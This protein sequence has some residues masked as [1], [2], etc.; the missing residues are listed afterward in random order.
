MSEV[1]WQ[2]SNPQVKGKKGSSIFFSIHLVGWLFWVF[3]SL[4]FCSLWMCPAYTYRVSLDWRRAAKSGFV[5]C[6]K[7]APQ[8]PAA[9]SCPLFNRALRDLTPRNWWELGTGGHVTKAKA[10]FLHKTQWPALPAAGRPPAYRT[11]ALAHGWSIDKLCQSNNFD[12]K[13]S[14]DSDR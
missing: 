11:A 2:I 9:A 4:T 13:N 14:E 8:C 3:D 12:N 5:Q 10:F 7:H 1:W 6:F